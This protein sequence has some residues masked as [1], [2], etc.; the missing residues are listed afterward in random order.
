MSN[1]P[2]LSLLALFFSAV[3]SLSVA[4]DDS[5]PTPGRYEVSTQTEYID[6]EVPE[7]TITTQSCLTAEDLEAG[8][9]TLFAGLPKSQ[10]CEVEDFV[11]AGGV[12]SMTLSCA[13]P[14]GDMNMVTSGTYTSSGYSMTSNVTIT[15]GDSAV[16]MHSEI[17]GTR[18]GDC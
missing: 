3:S 17:L 12:I 18:V 9:A 13:A 5:P 16:E 10:N 8:A 1:R 15:V 6:V 11:M 7:T 4:N 2:T 14:D